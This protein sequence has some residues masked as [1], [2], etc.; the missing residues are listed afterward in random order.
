MMKDKQ[1]RRKNLGYKYCCRTRWYLIGRRLNFPK[2]KRVE[3]DREVSDESALESINPKKLAIQFGLGIG[4]FLGILAVFGLIYKEQITKLA[5]WFVSTLGGFGSALAFFLT[6]AIV[7]P[8]PP[9]PAL[10]FALIGGQSY[11]TVLLWA[12]TGSLLGGIT[13]FGIGR[14]ISKTRLFKKM[15]SG[16]GA[17]AYDLVEKYGAAGLAMASLTPIPY[18]AG[19]WASGALGMRFRIFV[20]V[21]M[22][23]YLRVAIYLFL[24]KLGVVTLM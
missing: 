19:S 17:K 11:F 5:Q 18:S 21:S 6:D 10:A 8:V 7:I 13:G 1:E 20:T 12:G 15:M 16:Q 2:G 3:Q 14:L 22:L 23:R 24:F 4:L 9:D